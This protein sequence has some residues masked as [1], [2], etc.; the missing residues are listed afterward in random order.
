M[1]TTCGG[2]RK[3]KK[4]GPSKSIIIG[5]RREDM[6]SNKRGKKGKAEVMI[7]EKKEGGAAE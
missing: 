4:E 7:K 5:G 1:H 3:K 2:I 6:V